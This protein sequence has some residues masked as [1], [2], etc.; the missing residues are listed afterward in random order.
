MHLAHWLT[1]A[2]RSHGELALF[3]PLGLGTAGDAIAR[4]S[5]DPAVRD[6][7]VSNVAVA[8][9]VT[10]LA[11]L[12]TAVWVLSAYTRHN[13]RAYRTWCCRQATR[14]RWPSSA[15]SARASS[16]CGIH[17]VRVTGRTPGRIPTPEKVRESVDR[18]WSAVACGGLNRQVDASTGQDLAVLPGN[19][20]V[21]SA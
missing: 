19:S 12:I 14:R 18:D 16:G 2:L 3:L 6:Q 7:L 4:L 15:Y 13:V 9:A 20:I 8:F 17:L 5:P 10:C 1:E 11:G 21:G